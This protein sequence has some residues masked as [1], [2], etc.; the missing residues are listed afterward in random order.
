MNRG[1]RLLR[2]INKDQESRISCSTSS[3]VAFR[4]FTGE[5][6]MLNLYRSIQNCVQSVNTWEAEP[7]QLQMRVYSWLGQGWNS[8]LVEQLWIMRVRIIKG[9]KIDREEKAS[10]AQFQDGGFQWS[11]PP[12][13]TSQYALG[14]CLP[15]VLRVFHTDLLSPLEMDMS[16]H[17]ASLGLEWITEGSAKRTP[18]T[19]DIVEPRKGKKETLRHPP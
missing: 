19:T 16:E 11:S 14:M 5:R 6:L 1:P 12:N 18:T 13:P 8:T 3:F 15:G 2:L 9:K 10:R 17:W 4:K 7:W